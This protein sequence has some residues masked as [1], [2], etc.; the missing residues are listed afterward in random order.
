MIVLSYIPPPINDLC[1]QL[2]VFGQVSRCSNK[3]KLL[4]DEGLL[5]HSQQLRESLYNNIFAHELK[6]CDLG[7][8]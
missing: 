8:L 5:V 3:P 7:D 6:P 1:I 4:T 2:D